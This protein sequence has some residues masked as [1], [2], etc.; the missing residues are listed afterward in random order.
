LAAVQGTSLGYWASQAHYHQSMDSFYACVGHASVD[1]H[2]EIDA[3]ASQPT[4]TP[5]K[6]Y[7]MIAGGMAANA[8]VAM[9]RLG[10]RVKLLGRVGDDA[11]GDFVRQAVQN[12]GVHTLLE[13]V[14]HSYTSVSSVVVDARGERQIF[15]HRGDALDKAHALDVHQLLGAR[16]VLA[17]P[18]WCPGALAALQWAKAHQVLSMLDADVAPQADLRLLVPAAQWAVFSEPGLACYA[19]AA[20]SPA[21]GLASALA[22]G[23]QVAMVTLG[24]RGVLWSHGQG[25][26]SMPGFQVN[27]VDTT[28]AGDVFHA[29][30]A[31]ALS[32]T[33]DEARAIRFA[34]AAA[35]LKCMQRYGVVGTPSRHQVE[36]YLLQNK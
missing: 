23:A 17:D 19:P 30:L 18:R 21:D 9:A 22:A 12:G 15:N 28:G 31:L 29:A 7:R 33:H 25:M 4:K 2:F 16:A 32:E 11:S 34:S 35:A 3:F 26:H 1:H 20:A 8:A 36:Q 27:A 24:E 6:S 13:T 5:A 10:A 14:P